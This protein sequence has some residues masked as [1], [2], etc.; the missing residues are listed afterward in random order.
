MDVKRPGHQK[1][2]CILSDTLVETPGIAL[3]HMVSYVIQL[4]CAV[5]H[6]IALL[7]LARGLCLTRRL[8]TSCMYLVVH[9]GFFLTVPTQKFL[10]TRKNQSTQTVPMGTVLKCQSMVKV[11]ILYSVPHCTMR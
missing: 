6:A 8:Y 7:A 10:N 1:L 2:F 5:L 4:H 9:G 11:K 3:Y